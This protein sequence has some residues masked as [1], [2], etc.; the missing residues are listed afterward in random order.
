[1]TA[2]SVQLLRHATLLVRIGGIEFLVDPMLAEPG[3]M[4][5]IPNSPNDRRNPL[6]PLPDVEIDPDAVVVTHTHRD[7]LDDAARERLAADVPLYCQPPDEF[8][9][10]T[11]FDDVRPVDDRATFVGVELVRT[12][13]RHGHDDLADSMGPVSGFVFRAADEP[14][15]FVAGDTVWCPELESALDEHEPDVV[16]LNAGG[17]R[18][19]EGEPITMTDEDVRRVRER[20]PDATV[21]AVHMDAINHCLLSR[22]E[23]ANAVEGVLIPADG[24]R[25]ELD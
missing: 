3:E 24:E 19:V 1:M 12:G 9:I 14:S 15:I 7:H 23:L 11:D 10:E 18:F 20:V 17:A 4:P 25:V 22:E 13:G 21:V 5:P 16:V 6:V 8:E 2:A